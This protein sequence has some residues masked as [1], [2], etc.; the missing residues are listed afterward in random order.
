MPREVRIEYPGAWYHVFNRGAG[1]Q[2]VFE[3]QQHYELFLEL[4]SDAY[5]R[6][7]IQIHAYCLMDDHYHLLIHTPLPNLGVAMKHI[8]G[9]YTVRHNRLVKKKEGALFRGRYKA[10]LIDSENYVLQLS[11]YIHLNPVQAQVVAIPERYPWS[12]YQYFLAQ[13]HKPHWLFIR[14]V[15]NRFESPSSE[16]Y[17]K[18]VMEGIELDKKMKEFIASVKHTGILGSS[19]FSKNILETMS[20]KTRLDKIPGYPELKSQAFPTIDAVIKATALC[21]EVSFSEII[22]SN[23]TVEN[24]PRKVAMYLAYLLTHQNRKVIARA[25]GNVS[26]S[27][28]SKAYERV[29]ELMGKDEQLREKIKSLKFNLSLVSA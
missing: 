8:N 27:A 2:T 26:N 1:R 20:N 28:V 10:I 13:Q 12:S 6:F 19:S 9:L 7:E 22:D 5:S 15:L 24:L 29:E 4:L 21:F 16:N 23:K 3:N 25:F 14:E 11:R 17:K 18:F